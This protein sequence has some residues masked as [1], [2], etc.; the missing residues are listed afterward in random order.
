MDVRDLISLT[1]VMEELDLGPNGG[2]VCCGV[3][4]LFFTDSDFSGLIYCIEFLEKNLDWLK[5]KLEALKGRLRVL[6]AVCKLVTLLVHFR[7]VFII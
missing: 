7:K 3:M 5:E 1:D 4:G 6:Y 2:T